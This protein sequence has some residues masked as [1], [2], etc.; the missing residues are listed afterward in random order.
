MRTLALLLI[1]L[2]GC[3]GAAVGPD[4]AIPDPEPDFD[5]TTAWIEV[6]ARTYSD[7]SGGDLRI[8]GRLLTEAPPWPYDVEEVVD[9]CRYS[10]RLPMTCAQC[11]V[12]EVCV[13]TTCVA[14]PAVRSAG[15]ITVTGGGDS[16]T[17]THDT[18][19]Q[20][21]ETGVPFAPGVALTVSAPGDEVDAFELTGTTPAAIELL[22]RDQLQLRVGDPLVIRWTPDDPGSRVRLTLGADLGHAQYRAA[23][24]ECDAPDEHGAIAVPQAM[25]D[26]FADGANWGCGDCY[27]HELRRY[28]R[29]RATVGAV[30]VSL[31]VTEVTSLYLIPE[32]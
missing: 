25:L 11:D 17:V 28:R 15:P 21:Y 7:G 22:D 4:A 31:W 1:L 3:D 12:D 8:D 29:D 5:D 18:G 6:A 14:L 16:R 9:G 13:D 23:L 27:P 2:A 19:Y 32:R 26:R 24:I 10:T 20:L 30:P